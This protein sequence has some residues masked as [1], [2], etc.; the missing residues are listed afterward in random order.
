M[1]ADEK[2]GVEMTREWAAAKVRYWDNLK[3]LQILFNA[4]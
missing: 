2:Q 4:H 3:K 1:A